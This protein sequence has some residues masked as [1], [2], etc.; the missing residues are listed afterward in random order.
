MGTEIN[1]V[2]LIPT[3]QF[4]KCTVEDWSGLAFLKKVMI[5]GSLTSILKFHLSYTGPT[6]KLEDPAGK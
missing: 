5:N 1:N 2:F 3:E 6:D 4:R